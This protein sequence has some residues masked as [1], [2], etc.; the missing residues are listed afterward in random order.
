MLYIVPLL[1]LPKVIHNNINACQVCLYRNAF[2]GICHFVMV[3]PITMFS[4]FWMTSFLE[5]WDP[6]V[7]YANVMAK[8]KSTLCLGIVF[9]PIINFIGYQFFPFHLRYLCF[10]FFAFIWSIILSC[11]NHKRKTLA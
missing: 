5:H 6:A 10:D 11:I 4:F 1:R 3:A 7:A 8:Y 9:G 2:R